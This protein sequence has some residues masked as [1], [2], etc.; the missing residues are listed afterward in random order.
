MAKN[1]GLKVS[2]AGS[3]VRSSNPR[4][5]LLSSKYPML[6]FSEVQTD[7]ITLSPGATTGAVNFTH[8]LSHTPAFI[9]YI[10]DFASG[11]QYFLA[12]PGGGIDFGVLHWSYADATKIRCGLELVGFTYSGH[13]SRLGTPPPDIDM[14]NTFDGDGTHFSVGRLDPTGAFDGAFRFADVGVP[15]GATI[16]SAQ[17]RIGVEDKGAGTAA[18]KFKIWGID[19]DDTAAFSGS[20]MARTKTTAVF[21]GATSMNISTGGHIG[22]DVKE[23]VQEIVNRGGWASGNAIGFIMEDNGSDDTN[24][25]QDDLGSGVESYLTIAYGS[26]VEVT[27]RCIIFKDK[28][29]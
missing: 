27:V 18:L 25:I 28:L 11:E 15:Q 12:N 9:A 14:W 17:L 21:V 1:W 26:D 3:E 5:I 19:E 10:E 16:V 2:K 4:D 7:T 13:D 8:G 6:K 29:A 23:E 24:W 22:F 20:P